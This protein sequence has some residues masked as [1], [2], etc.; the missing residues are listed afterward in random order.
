[1]TF[2]NRKEEVVQIELTRLGRQKLS[3][4]QFRPAYYEFLDEDVLYD[5]KNLSTGSSEE[6]NDI[7]QRIK[8]K[9]SLRA[10]TARQSV[11][12]ID[13]PYLPENKVMESLGSFIPYSNYRPAWNI[14]A[15][16]GVLFSGSGDMNF[17]SIEAASGSGLT[18]GPT[19]EN[20]PQLTLVCDYD[21]NLGITL[22]KNDPDF[23]E[24]ID[25]N[26]ALEVDDVLKNP[27]DDT[28]ILFEKSFNDFTIMVQE[29]NVL[30]SK[31]DFVLEV[32]KYD[33]V[34]D[35]GEEK[36]EI[37]QLFLDGQDVE[38]AFFFFDI[39]TDDLVEPAREGFTYV[40]EQVK[41]DSDDDECV[42][43]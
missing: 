19:Y 20:V 24:T 15:Q 1:M 2:F 8:E 21:Y 5:R 34:D 41:T 12:L 10:L 17:V 32:F 7:K 42:D 13:K 26:F 18:V 31:D 14:T 9:I 23:I 4:G 28:Y 33:Y 37:N 29:E 39:T 11:P 35:N 40:D 27:G 6:Q 38:S 36:V 16:D 43:V 22:T 25:N 3:M 30:N